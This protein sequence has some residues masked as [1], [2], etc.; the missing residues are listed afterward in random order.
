MM[1]G[2]KLAFPRVLYRLSSGYVKWVTIA[3]S[4]KHTWTGYVKTR[5][6]IAY[7]IKLA[8]SGLLVRKL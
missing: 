6:N 2:S 8:V 4:D 5:T 3:I 1:H 7:T